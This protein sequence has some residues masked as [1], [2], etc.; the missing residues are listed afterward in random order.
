MQEGINSIIES[1]DDAALAQ[2]TPAEL[3]VTSA[4]LSRAIS[5]LYDMLG[6]SEKPDNNNAFQVINQA[7][8]REHFKEG[9][10]KNDE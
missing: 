3:D 5:A 4:V 2:L 1:I 8:G 9:N 7:L 10:G 6:R